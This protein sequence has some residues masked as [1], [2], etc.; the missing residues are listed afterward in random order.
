MII[1]FRVITFILV[2]DG[3]LAVFRGQ[4]H[5]F[6]LLHQL[7][8]RRRGFLGAN[9]HLDLHIAVIKNALDIMTQA[10]ACLRRQV[11]GK[12]HPC[13]FLRLLGG[14]SARREVRADPFVVGVHPDTVE[15]F[16][17]PFNAVCPPCRIRR[18]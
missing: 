1:C 11:C 6:E 14:C 17:I 4:S 13:H 10:E 2:Q 9:L 5:A 18:G 16:G 12:R 8:D 15:E 7:S 3:R